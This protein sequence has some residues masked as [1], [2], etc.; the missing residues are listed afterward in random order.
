MTATSDIDIAA[1][2]RAQGLVGLG[3]VTTVQQLVEAVREGVAAA[4][5][6]RSVVIDARVE[7]GYNAAMAKGMVREGAG[8]VGD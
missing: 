4:R 2:A 6:G 3:P 5:A 7:P 8:K 1:I